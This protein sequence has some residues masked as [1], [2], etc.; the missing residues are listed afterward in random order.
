[1]SSGPLSEL[2]SKL[3]DE[4]NMSPLSKLLSKLIDEENMSHDLPIHR[5]HLLMG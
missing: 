5:R 1:M 3:T 4:E 2:L